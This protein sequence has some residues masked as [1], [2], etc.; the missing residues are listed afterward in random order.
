MATKGASGG[1]ILDYFPGGD[2]HFS[3]PAGF[4]F[5]EGEISLIFSFLEGEIAF[6]GRTGRRLSYRVDR[7]ARRLPVR[8]AS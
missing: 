5:L 8:A 1:Y 2:G 6:D 7:Q 3:S 4:S